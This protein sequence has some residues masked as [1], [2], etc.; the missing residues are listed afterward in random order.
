MN[1]GNS[2]TFPLGYHLP[3]AFQNVV[4]A[5]LCLKYILNILFLLCQ[6]YMLFDPLI[7]GVTELHD[8]HRDLRLD[9]DNMSYEVKKKEHSICFHLI[10]FIPAPQ[11]EYE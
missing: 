3:C 1:K 10:D 9:V 4:S 2:T 5:Q 11:T 7:T 6:D 8:R